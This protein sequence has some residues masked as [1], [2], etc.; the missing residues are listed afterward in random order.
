MGMIEGWKRRFT[1]LEERM[2]TIKRHVLTF[3]LSNVPLKALEGFAHVIEE[4]ME[5]AIKDIKK[6][7]CK[8][9][10]YSLNKSKSADVKLPKLGGKI[11]SGFLQDE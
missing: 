9:G 8:R 10:L 4:K 1:K 6:H 3:G 11:E 5:E 2:L 7:D